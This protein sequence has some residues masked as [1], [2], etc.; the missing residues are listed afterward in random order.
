MMMPFLFK[1]AESV[2][3]QT[4]MCGLIGG[5]VTPRDPPGQPTGGFPRGYLTATAF[6]PSPVCAAIPVLVWLGLV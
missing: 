1:V 5:K 3:V 6:T 2:A 4:H